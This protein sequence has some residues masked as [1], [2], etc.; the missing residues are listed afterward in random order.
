MAFT[1]TSQTN[2]A[3]N[4]QLEGLSGDD[5]LR[6]ALSQGFAGDAAAKAGHFNAPPQ[7]RL[8]GQTTAAETGAFTLN[9][10]T[11]TRTVND[12]QASP[13]NPLTKQL[14]PLSGILTTG[15]SRMLRFR[16][17]QVTAGAVNIF[18]CAAVATGAATPTVTNPATT[19][20]LG[21]KQNAADIVSLS[22][23][24]GSLTVNVV[25]GGAVTTVWTV[26]VFTDD[27][28]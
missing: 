12:P 24:A 9:L 28:Q 1:I 3:Y 10:A 26:D 5:G 21:T 23:A 15:V 13:S 6:R 17:K 7:F 22:A 18:W 16:V 2:L 19:S 20:V 14:G 25:A 8:V 4:E 11:S 27:P